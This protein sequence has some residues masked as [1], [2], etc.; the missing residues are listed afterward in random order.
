MAAP[1]ER[2][3][4]GTAGRR[5]AQ[6]SQLG[7]EVPVKVIVL[8]GYGPFGMP[9]ARQLASSPLIDEVVVSGRDLARAQQAA[10]ELGAK[11]RARQLGATDTAG[12]AGD[13]RGLDLVVNLLPEPARLQEPVM[14]A[15]IEAGVHF[16]GVHGHEPAP[17]LHDQAARAGVTLLHG[18]GLHPG[19]LELIGNLAHELLDEVDSAVEGWQW[20]TL[21]GIVPDLYRRHLPLPGGLDRGPK[22]ELLPALLRS[23]GGGEPLF[24]AIR[25]ARIIEASLHVLSRS[26]PIAV[27][28][29]AYRD[30][31]LRE[32]DPLEGGVDVPFGDQGDQGEHGMTN[33]SAL[34]VSRVGKLKG[35][36]L[37]LVHLRISGLAAGFDKMIGQLASHVRKGKLDFEAAVNRA[38]QALAADPAAFLLPADVFAAR[39]AAFRVV[40]GR[41]DGLPARAAAWCTESWWTPRNWHDLTAANVALSALRLLRGDIAA[42]G[43][44]RICQGDR[45]DEAYLSE[46]AARLP[47]A[48]SDGMIGTL[49]E[50]VGSR[51]AARQAGNGG[52]LT[53][54]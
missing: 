49:F 41:K 28:T 53:S 32:V 19:F 4:T 14:R 23:A 20:A 11:G 13:F 15:A 42:R 45:L 3:R 21:Q 24:E 50:Y 7:L 16:C 6:L 26:A 31:S 30:G 35:S 38:Q 5:R 33:A 9:T 10:S 47:E 54:P 25:D 48:P 43:L 34:A 39:P 44:V 18:A 29:P 12:L 17:E 40:Y 37:P 2:S 8:G 46:L 22:A 1:V 36:E 51:E 52:A 27:S